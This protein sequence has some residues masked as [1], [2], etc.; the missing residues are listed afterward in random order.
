MKTLIPKLQNK[1]ILVTEVPVK[2]KNNNNQQK[3]F[4]MSIM[5]ISKREVC[6]VMI[7]K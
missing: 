4:K 6:R 7:G 1:I 5:K 3:R 2:G